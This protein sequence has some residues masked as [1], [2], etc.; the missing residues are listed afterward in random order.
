[1]IGPALALT[2]VAPSPT[3]PA[4]ELNT[5]SAA[6]WLAFAVPYAHLLVSLRRAVRGV[7]RRESVAEF[8]TS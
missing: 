5:L 2:G 6:L 1:M 3:G 8:L 7:A 4:P